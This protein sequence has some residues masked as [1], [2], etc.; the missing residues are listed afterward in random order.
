VKGLD[1][2]RLKSL[3]AY[4]LVNRSS[5]LPRQQLAFLFWTETSDAQAQTNLRQLLH[6]LQ[7]RLPNAER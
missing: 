3:L 7:H 1:S 5:P 6:R 2:S 4:L